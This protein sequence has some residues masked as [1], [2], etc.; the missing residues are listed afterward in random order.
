MN[1]GTR[2]WK[3]RKA[4]TDMQAPD[5]VVLDLSKSAARILR[6]MHQK[7]RYGIRSAFRQ[8][9]LVEQKSP[10]TLPLWHQLY[11]E[12]AERKGIVAEALPYFREFFSTARDRGPDL[13]LYLAFRN[14]KL[15]AGSIIAFHLST[16]YY[17]YSASSRQGRKFMASYAVLWKAIMHAKRGGCRWFD[18]FGIPSTAR[19]DHPMHGLYRFKT[20]FGG[21]IRHFRGSWDYPLDEERYPSLAFAEGNFNPYH[22]KRR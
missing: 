18:L 15:L 11:L 12:M 3:L 20:R 6:D 2:N 17:L 1:F 21:K 16:A 9:I 22:L 4:P 7:T 5:T 14:G 10:E 19:S 13:R 8:G